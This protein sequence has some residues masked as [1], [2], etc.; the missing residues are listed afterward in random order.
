MRRKIKAHDVGNL[1]EWLVREICRGLLLAL[2]NVDLDELKRN[3]F[4]VQ[5]CCNGASAGGEVKSV[6]FENH[7][8]KSSER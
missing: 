1:S 2:A 4:L 7:C 5:H 6:E 8:E 3:F